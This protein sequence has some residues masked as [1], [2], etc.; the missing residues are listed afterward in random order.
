LANP[1]GEIEMKGLVF[2][3]IQFGK[4]GATEGWLVDLFVMGT[5][6]LLLVLIVLFTI[7][8]DRAE[9]A[10]APVLPAS[11]ETGQI[12]APALAPG[13]IVGLPP[14]GTSYLYQPE[15]LQALSAG[16]KVANAPAL[17]SGN[18]AGL[19]SSGTSYLYQPDVLQAL[20]ARVEAANNPVTSPV[21][22]AERFNREWYEA[23][24]SQFQDQP[25]ATSSQP[26]EAERFTSEWYEWYLNE[27]GVRR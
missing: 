3:R 12:I 22:E 2:K 24:L 1:Q 20:N 26:T 27:S 18:V 21:S 11:N 16:A 19:P 25:A 8:G 14:S 4:A 6:A 15:A 17:A 5:A 9:T 13:T 23:H 7:A 10:I